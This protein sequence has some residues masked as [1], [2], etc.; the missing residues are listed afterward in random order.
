MVRRGRKPG[1]QRRIAR[2]RINILF[3]LAEKTL[4][5]HPE[6][7]RRY[8]ELARKIGLRYNVRLPKRLKRRFCKRCNTLLVPGRTCEVRVKEKILMVR[9]LNCSKI[10]RY[11]L[12]KKKK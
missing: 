9:C 1:W 2:E 11:P 6:R 4:A 10:Y 7:S 8:V 12:S 3:R 5:K